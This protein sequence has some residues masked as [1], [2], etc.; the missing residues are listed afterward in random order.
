MSDFHQGGAITTLHRLGPTNL[1]ALER[2]LEK[3][4][5]TRPV[6]LVLPCLA[7]EFDTGAIPRIIEELQQVRYLEEIVVALGRARGE[8]FAAALKT[9]RQHEDGQGVEA[10]ARAV[11][12]VD[13]DNA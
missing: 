5:A 10:F 6:A 2:D 11:A 7:S 1:D 12:A 8:R 4:A 3:T 9:F 13:R